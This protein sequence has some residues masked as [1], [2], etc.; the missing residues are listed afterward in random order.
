MPSRWPPRAAARANAAAVLPK[1]RMPI[2]APYPNQFVLFADL[3]GFKRLVLD[4][5]T[6]T[7]DEL[8]FRNPPRFM[9]VGSTLTSLYSDIRPNNLLAETFIAFHKAVNDTV[10]ETSWLTPD[11]PASIYVFSD[12]VFVAAANVGDCLGFAERLMG[13]C[14]AEHAPIRMGVGFGSFIPFGFEFQESPSNI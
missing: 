10:Q 1:A 5:A 12:S 8:D 2:M 4:S 9:H 6:P 7:I 14:I 3:L 11:T 13:L